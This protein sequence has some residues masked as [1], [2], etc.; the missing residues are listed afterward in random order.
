MKLKYSTKVNVSFIAKLRKE[1]EC[2]IS[3]AKEALGNTNNDYD[4]ALQWLKDDLAE[5]AL[6]KSEK[7]SNRVTVEGLVGIYTHPMGISGSLVELNCETDFVAKA[8]LFVNLVSKVTKTVSLFETGDNTSHNWIKPV[9][10]A[11]LLQRNLVDSEQV[12]TVQE[13]CRG[14]IGKLGENIQIRRGIVAHQDG[15]S[16]LIIGGYAHAA[17]QVLPPG[18]GRLG[19]IVVLEA[20]ENLQN[21]QREVLATFANKLAQHISGFNPSS[22]DLKEGVTEEYALLEQS[23]LFGGGSVR[24]VLESTGSKLNVKLSVKEF[25]R[26][27]CGEGLEK[28]SD[29]FAEEVRAQIKAIEK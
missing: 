7:L 5:S 20:S 21:N 28:K 3:K 14:V 25:Q 19:S 1:T 13:S 24:E 10:I 18:L 12:E 11:S 26:L 9:D 8:S 17:G 27:E 2:T 6:K 29:N 22:I 16:N 4:L 23:Y 15:Q